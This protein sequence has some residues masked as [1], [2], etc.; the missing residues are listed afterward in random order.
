MHSPSHRRRNRLRWIAAS[1]GAILVAAILPGFTSTA[2]AAVTPGTWYAITNEHSGLVVDIEARSTA[3][4]AKALLWNRT[5]AT[6]QQFRFVDAGGGYYRIEAR[7]SGQVLDVNAK[8]TANGAD[9]VQY[10]NN[11]GTN[12]QWQL[13]EQ[14]NGSYEIVNRNSGK[15]LDNWEAATAPG[16]RVSQYDRNGSA[17]QRWRLVPVGGAQA[18]NGSVSDPNLQYYG[19]WAPDG[20]WRTMGWAGGYVEAAFTGSTIGVHLRNSIDMYYSV[21]GA[22]E[23]W[24]RGVSGDVTIASGLGSGTHTVRIGFRERAGSYTGDPAFGGF[25]LASGGSTTSIARPANFIEFIGDSITVGQPNG[26]RPFTAYPYLV[27]EDLGAGHTQV[28]QGG[29]CLVSTSDGCYGMMDWF[30]RS[31]AWVS[32]D[33]WNFSTYRA[34]AVVINLGTNDVGH[35]VS[36]TEFNRNYVVMLERVRQAYP[37]AEIFAM[38]VFRNRYVTET[39]N[40]VQARVDAGDTRV[41]FVDTT[42]WVDPAV[43][44]LDNVHPTD[45][46]HR[47]IANLL[48]PIIDRY[49]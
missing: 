12:Q 26:N 23:Q 8:S 35:G 29:A 44:T 16:S 7:H 36:T 1:L 31:S 39:R 40:A 4:G 19:R 45:A 41:H 32:N 10:P 42:G 33:D 17:V 47:K 5:D 34:T 30:R 28:A 43:D 24:R 2:T 46:G 3:N 21:D 22:P 6:N 37:N 18:G 14:S 20:S 25:N 48:A 38:G 15:A 27:G 13:N 9:I 11:G 49:I